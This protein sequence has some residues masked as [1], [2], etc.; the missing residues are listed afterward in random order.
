MAIFW[1][2]SNGIPNTMSRDLSQEETVVVAAYPS[3]HDAEMAKDFL[4]DQGI[5][6]FVVADDVHVQMQLLYDVKTP[7]EYLRNSRRDAEGVRRST[8]P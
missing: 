6:T 2:C 7:A 4:L 5:H 3:R 1:W 8:G